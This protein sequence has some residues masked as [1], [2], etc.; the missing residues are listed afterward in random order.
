MKLPCNQTAHP[1]ISQIGWSCHFGG[2]LHFQRPEMTTI[3]RERSKHQVRLFIN[4]LVKLPVAYLQ[5]LKLR[6]FLFTRA[7]RKETDCNP[8]SNADH[9]T[10]CKHCRWNIPLKTFPSPQQAYFNASSLLTTYVMSDS[11]FKASSS[12]TAICFQSPTA[13]L[14][15]GNALMGWGYSLSQGAPFPVHAAHSWYRAETAKG[16]I[17][18]AQ[19]WTLEDTTALGNAPTDACI[20]GQL[21][22]A[23]VPTCGFTNSSHA[24]C[25][26]PSSPALPELLLVDWK[27]WAQ[28]QRPHLW[29][30][31]RMGFPCVWTICPHTMNQ[32]SQDKLFHHPTILCAL[33]AQSCPEESI[34]PH[35]LCW[36]MWVLLVWLSDS[37]SSFQPYLQDRVGL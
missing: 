30:G 34:C 29:L 5:P 24:K 14:A 4:T 35:F 1:C 7:T 22:T 16:T 11:L 6:V 32:C 26:Y 28:L 23:H 15:V 27:G 13:L 21:P 2:F 3:Q 25:F 9:Y 18:T 19:D 33:T 20:R 10:Q 8:N 31:S 36:K 37:R 17:K 12:M